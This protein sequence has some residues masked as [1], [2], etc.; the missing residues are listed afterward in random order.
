[1][2][3]LVVCC[4]LNPLFIMALE[5]TTCG[6]RT[7]NVR[8]IPCSMPTDPYLSRASS[9]VFFQLRPQANTD[10]RVKISNLK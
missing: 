4:M 3:M 8:Q 6:L 10:S 7:P 2:Y 5:A 1:M 9:W